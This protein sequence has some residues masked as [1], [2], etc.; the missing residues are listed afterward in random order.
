M[1]YRTAQ[2]ARILLIQLS[3]RENKHSPPK[4]IYISRAPPA[5]R[6]R[7]LHANPR[8][9]TSSNCSHALLRTSGTAPCLGTALELLT[10]QVDRG[11]AKHRTNT[12]SP[13]VSDAR[14]CFG[15]LC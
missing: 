14:G 1:I 11:D 12:R 15:L 9:L 10:S 2:R 3:A 7:T 8:T 6:E 13:R 5:C 4:S